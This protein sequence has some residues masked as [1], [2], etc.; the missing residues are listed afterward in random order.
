MPQTRPRRSVLLVYAM[1][2]VAAALVAVLAVLVV[3]S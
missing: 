3:L 1:R 2:V